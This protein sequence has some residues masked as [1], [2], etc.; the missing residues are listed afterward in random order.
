MD[1]KKI[2]EVGDR[3]AEVRREAATPLLFQADAAAPLGVEAQQRAADGV[4]ARR[5]HEHVERVFARRGA[6]ACLCHLL[7]RVFAQVD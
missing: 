6:H 2:G 5:Q 3:H 1:Q 7:N 4:E